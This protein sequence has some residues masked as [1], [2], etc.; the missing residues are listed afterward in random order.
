MLVY[1]CLPMKTVKKMLEMRTRLMMRLMWVTRNFLNVEAVASTLRVRDGVNLSFFLM[2][3]LDGDNLRLFLIG[4]VTE[5]DL[6][7]LGVELPLY[8]ESSSS[9]WWRCWLVTDVGVS[10]L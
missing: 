7:D 2:S 6:V 5:T 1:F 9:L 4:F 10:R 8:P 3:L